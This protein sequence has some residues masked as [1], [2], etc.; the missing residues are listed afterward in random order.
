M[1]IT[2]MTNQQRADMVKWLSLVTGTVCILSILFAPLGVYI[3]VKG[4]KRAKV[5]RELPDDPEGI[6]SAEL[7]LVQSWDDMPG[8]DIDGE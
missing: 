5:L 8:V 2:E 4:L 7:G 6:T 3:I 1:P